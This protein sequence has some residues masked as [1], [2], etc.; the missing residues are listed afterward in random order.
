MSGNVLEFFIK[1][2]DLTGRAIA[3]AT[4]NVKKF[5]GNVAESMGLVKKHLDSGLA[6]EKFVRTTTVLDKFAMAMDRLGIKGE[7]FNDAYDTMERR[8]NNFNKTGEDADAL[9]QHFRAS[10]EDLGFSTNQVEQGLAMLQQNMVK[11]TE[12]VKDNTT[13]FSLLRTVNAAAR[14]DFAGMAA[15]L[16]KVI[17]AFQ[18]AGV[19][20]AK[21]MAI[22]GAAVASVIKLLGALKDLVSTVFNFGTAPKDIRD[23][24]GAV[25]EAQN[26]A[27]MFADAMKEARDAAADMTEKLNGEITALER[28]TKAQN[29]LARAQA[30]AAATTDY[31]RDEINAR[32]DSLNAQASEKAAG[33]RRALKRKN[34][35]DEAKRLEDEIEEAEKRRDDMR[36]RAVQYAKKSKER[37]G[38]WGRS[39]LGYIGS[40]F[41]L[42]GGYLEEATSISNASTTASNEA[43]KA[44]EEIA[45]ARKKLAKVRDKLRLAETEEKAAKIETETRK[46]TEVNEEATRDLKE[47][48]REVKEYEKQVRDATREREKAEKAAAKAASARH[49]QQMREAKEELAAEKEL[50]KAAQTRLEAAKES[51]S[52]AWGFYLDRE[53][54]S[55]YDAGQDREIEARKQ[56]EKDRQALMKGRYADE[57][58]ELRRIARRDGDDAV[59]AQLSEWRKKKSISLDTE[60]T[61]RVALAE[62]E[63]R[64]AIEYA[65]ETADAAERSAEALEA[66]QAAVVEG[67]E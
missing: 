64:M 21:G 52:K 28:L 18:K 39:L 25:V 14:G 24:Q 35:E 31:E 38:G 57:F 55:T 54:L 1:L 40:P 19:A 34:L 4:A 58:R 11:T 20:G 15:E 2:T 42:G 46:Q 37:M 45:E 26:S 7:E 44:E 47:Y 59:E 62:E 8:L 53:S 60:A 43:F 32:Y 66:I 56:Y 16:T 27:S 50:A 49:K 9:V 61:M 63:Q 33:D 22:A 41:R 65:K 48:E 23:M 51:V 3:T 36:E 67:G 17:P 13:R 6:P 30:L 29:E 10:M 12:A 5:A